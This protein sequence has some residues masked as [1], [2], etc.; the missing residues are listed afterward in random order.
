MQVLTPIRE[1]KQNLD[2]TTEVFDCHLL[3]R[4][5]DYLVLAYLSDRPYTVADARVPPGTLTI[6]H[7]RRGCDHIV[8]EMYSPKGRLFGHY[9]HLCHDIN[10]SDQELTW[11]HMALDIWVGPNGN[12]EI[13]DQDDLDTAVK[14]GQIGLS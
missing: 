8:W 13:L 1:I 12:S 5:A 4:D 9:I 7:Y 6:G 11:R 10:L 3:Y 14:T 2:G